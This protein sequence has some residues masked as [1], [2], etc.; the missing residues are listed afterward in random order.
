M[1]EVCQTRVPGR[2]GKMKL[3][4]NRWNRIFSRRFS[5]Y[6]TYLFT[7]LGISANQVTASM[8]A[9]GF[10]SFL[11]AVP[12][13]LWMNVAS[14]LFFLLFNILDCSDGEV[15]RW[16]KQCSH[17]GVYLDLAAHTFCNGPLWASCALHYYLIKP[18]IV[19]SLIAFATVMMALWSY[20]YR[21]IIPSIVGRVD[22]GKFAPGQSSHGNLISILKVVKYILSDSLFVPMVLIIL[23]IVSHFQPCVLWAGVIYGLMST[24]LSSMAN[25]VIGYRQIMQ[26]DSSR[27]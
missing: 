21:L 10:L 15:A 23:I 25:L 8:L 17:G 3:T 19:L 1:R 7:K 22:R 2:N 26:Y 18:S 9:V 11:C 27:Q 20:Y 14:L 24:F 5:I 13:K 16:T 4:G 12:D 6:F